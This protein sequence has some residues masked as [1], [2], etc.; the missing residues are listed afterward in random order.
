MR[1][2]APRSDQAD[3][4]SIVSVQ[5]QKSLL[6]LTPRRLSLSMRLGFLFPASRDVAR[7][8][9][10]QGAGVPRSLSARPQR[11]DAHLRGDTSAW[12][13]GRRALH[14]AGRPRGELP[15]TRD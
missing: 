2:G 1:R 10:T 5:T 12:T 14:A 4:D 15:Q 7:S 3:V 6:G 13:V 11:A 8:A 9:S